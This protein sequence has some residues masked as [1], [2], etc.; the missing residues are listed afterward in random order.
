MLLQY[1]LQLSKTPLIERYDV[2]RYEMIEGRE[3]SM[4]YSSSS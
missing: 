3:D 2:V 4:E 1:F